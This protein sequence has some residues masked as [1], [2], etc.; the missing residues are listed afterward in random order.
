M[1][2]YDLLCEPSPRIRSL[3]GSLRRLLMKSKPTPCV[4]RGPTTLPKRND[5]A[6]M[7]KRWQYDA[8]NASPASLLAP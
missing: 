6:R 2:T 7:P 3:V 1:C 8:S 4:W 5:A